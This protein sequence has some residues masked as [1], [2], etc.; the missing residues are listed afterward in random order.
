[1]SLQFDF[2][3]KA[4]RLMEEKRFTPSSTLR[5][6]LSR[7]SMALSLPDPATSRLNL[8]D[9]YA[10]R[11][12]SVVSIGGLFKCPRCTKW[13]LNAA[14]GFAIAKPDVFLTNY[15]VIEG[16]THTG[17]VARSI[18]GEVF[19]VAEVLAADRASDFAIIRI[20]GLHLEPIPLRADAR[21]GESVAVI[22]H[23]HSR[24]YSLT[25]GIISRY[26]TRRENGKGPRTEWMQITADFAR[27]SSGGPILDAS[28]NA[29]G[30]VSRTQSVE[31]EHGESNLNESK[32]PVHHAT[33]MVF[34]DCVPARAVLDAI[35]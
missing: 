14:T 25:T 34:H 28:G 21:P 9:L 1:M 11:R 33:Q 16:G 6:Q 26:F 5:S 10:K 29:I 2:D 18:H 30:I 35:R 8:P 24:P 27:G 31:E 32:E 4:N 13:H 20:P 22:S 15:H 3:R 7:T 17:L 12:E 19:A 23:P